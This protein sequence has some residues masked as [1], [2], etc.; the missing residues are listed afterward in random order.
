V[1]AEA[2]DGMQTMTEIERHTVESDA[3]ARAASLVS[4]GIGAEVDRQADAFPQGAYVVSVLATDARR[5][6]QVLGLEEQ[7]DHDMDEA[8]L[9]R[10][11]R[12]WLIPALI[13]AAAFIIV[14]IA[15]FYITFK[16][17]GG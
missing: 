15:A 4:Q 1:E 9:T 6:R 17:Q 10:S 8:E 13:I 16:L 2:Q 12:P 11:V 3:R 14:P 7:T 5:A